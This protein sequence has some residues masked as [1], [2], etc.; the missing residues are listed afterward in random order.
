MK[1][2]R[3][4][5]ALAAVLLTA[6]SAWAEDQTATYRVIGFSAPERLDDWRQVMSGMPEV[7]ADKVDFDKAQV[8]LRFDLVN[9]YPNAKPPKDPAPDVIM[10]RI[11]ELLRKVSRGTFSLTALST[12]P[13]DKIQQLDLRIGILDCK[14]CRYGTY[15]AIAKMDGVERASIDP[16]KNMLHAWIDPE[17]TNEAAI[18]DAL[19]KAR[20]ELPDSP[21]AAAAK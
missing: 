18:K 13:A 5:S 10:K 6:S 20:V 14:G 11:D 12:V 2:T 9:L 19:T 21:P 4:L 3:I 1:P 7:Q 8:T 17:K 15:L 16:D